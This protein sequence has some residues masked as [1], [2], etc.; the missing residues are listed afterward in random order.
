[1]SAKRYGLAVTYL[2]MAGSAVAGYLSW[3]K[4]F[5]GAVWCAGGASCDV[6]NAS[7]YAQIIGIPVAVLGL[8]AYL[9]VLGLG[10]LWWHLGGA[11]PVW[12]P[13]ACT[14]ISTVGWTFSAYLTWVEA[15]VLLAYCIWCVISFGI[16]TLLLAVTVRGTLRH[17]TDGGH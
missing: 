7:P 5:G 4:L 8:V 11:V 13:L 1:M 12:I 17:Q 3:Y 2:A 15:N 9:A 16:L 14:G 6:V 10:V